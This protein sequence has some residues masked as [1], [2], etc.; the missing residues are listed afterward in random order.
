MDEWGFCLLGTEWDG[1][2][3]LK[4]HIFETCNDLFRTNAW[5]KRVRGGGGLTYVGLG[6]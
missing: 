5:R 3:G 6:C 4:F 1:G 2:E